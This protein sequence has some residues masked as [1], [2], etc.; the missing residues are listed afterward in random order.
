MG[1]GQHSF[2]LLQDGIVWAGQC[3]AVAATQSGTTFLPRG[4]GGVPGAGVHRPSLQAGPGQQYAVSPALPPLM[5]SL[6]PP[7]APWASPACLHNLPPP[8][9]LCVWQQRPHRGDRPP[10]AWPCGMLAAFCPCRPPAGPSHRS[11]P[12]A[13]VGGPLAGW[14]AA[15]R[16]R[17]LLPVCRHWH[18][19]QQHQRLLG[20]VCRGL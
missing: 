3:A 17:L 4:P 15:W 13:Q 20:R 12:S 1:I 16:S 10:S 6:G 11:R 19:H 8:W 9:Q 7:W 5:G 14:G 18:R 2:T